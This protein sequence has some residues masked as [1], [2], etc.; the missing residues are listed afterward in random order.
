[1]PFYLYSALDASCKKLEG[2]IQAQSANEA[3][4][5]LIVRGFRTPKIVGEKAGAATTAQPKQ[6]IQATPIQINVPAAAPA[7]QIY[8]S[9]KSSDRERFFLF[10][11]I[12]DQLRAG[13]NPAQA[14]GELA[15]TYKGQKFR[16][17]LAMVAAAASEGRPISDVLALWPDLYPEHVVG[18]VR[19]GEVGGFLPDAAATISEQAMNAHKFKRFHWW[20]WIVGFNALLGIPLAFGFRHSLLAAWDA[21]EASQGAGG[22]ID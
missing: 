4:H 17:S 21:A 19:A 9:R 22:S 7:A 15:R 11:Q 16:D 8:R 6:V 10:A 2:T 20:I 14:F 1:M 18:L 12:A 13:I 3:L 5:S